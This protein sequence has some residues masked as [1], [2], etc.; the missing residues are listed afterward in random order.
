[1]RVVGLALLADCLASSVR[2][3][4][5]AVGALEAG[6]GVEGLAEGVQHNG[7]LALNHPEVRLA[8]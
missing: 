5:V 8:G 4:I 1:M 7:A 6:G 2:P 3:E